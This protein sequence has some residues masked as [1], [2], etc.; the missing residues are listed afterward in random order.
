MIINKYGIKIDFEIAIIHMDDEKRERIH[1]EFA[2]CAD[3]KF[4]NEYCKLDEDFCLNNK[5]PIY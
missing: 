1:S 2:P 3:Q 5:N 4:F